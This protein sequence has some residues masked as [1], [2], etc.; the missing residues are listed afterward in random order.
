MDNKTNPENNLDKMS[1]PIE[2]L[3]H[4]LYLIV[5]DFLQIFIGSIFLFLFWNRNLVPI[6]Y[7]R[8]PTLSYFFIV[9]AMVSLTIIVRIISTAWNGVYQNHI[10]INTNIPNNLPSK[11]ND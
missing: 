3:Y 11:N 8:I 7:F 2:K 4:S 10:V 9:S 6:F 5:V 1:S